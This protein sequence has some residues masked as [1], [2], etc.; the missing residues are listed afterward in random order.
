[1]V[2]F[3]GGGNF[4]GNAHDSPTQLD[5]PPLANQGVVVVT[6]Q[7]RLGIL[8]FLTTPQLAAEDVSSAGA[9]AMLDMIAA[10]KWVQ[11]NIA[12]F[13]GDPTRVLLFGQS[14]GSFNIQMLLAAPP[15]QGLFSA[16]GMVSGA[17]P[18]A[19]QTTWLLSNSAAAAT[20]GPFISAMGCSNAADVLTCLRG[21]PVTTIVNY[22][23]NISLGPGFGTPFFPIDS[24][25]YLQQHGSPVPLLIGSRV[26]K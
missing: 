26:H 20:T 5:V 10:L 4:A 9:Y 14:A 13:G 12:A 15:A 8:G 7:Y 24:F 18:L 22:S 3:H 17:A 2:F 19:S 23:G 11:Q 21:V 1:M 6:A 25:A 16:A